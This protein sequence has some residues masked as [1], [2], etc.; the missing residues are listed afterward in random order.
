[1][2]LRLTLPLL[3]ALLCAPGVAQTPDPTDR[4]LL[5]AAA[6]MREAG[7]AER[8]NVLLIMA[9]DLN[10]ALGSYLE[11]PRPPR[12]LYR[13]RGRRGRRAGL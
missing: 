9:D 4:L 2:K 1:M 6:P 11:Y 5:P 13:P 12:V 8:P 7:L 3:A 10:V